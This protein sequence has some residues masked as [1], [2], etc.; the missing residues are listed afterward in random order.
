MRMSVRRRARPPS[1]GNDV[2]VGYDAMV[3]PGV[4]IGNGAI[5]SSGAVVVSDVPDYGIVDDLERIAP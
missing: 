2:W 4:S 3:M 5:I 1:V